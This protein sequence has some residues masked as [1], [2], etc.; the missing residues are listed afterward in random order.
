M[1]AYS[2]FNG[3]TAIQLP[4]G[5]SHYNSLT[6]RVERRIKTLDF[7]FNYAYSIGWMRTAI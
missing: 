7:V 4:S 3:V 2:L 5:T 1:R 6:V